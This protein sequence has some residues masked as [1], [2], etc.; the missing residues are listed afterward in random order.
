MIDIQGGFSII[1]KVA[2]THIFTCHFFLPNQTD[3][4]I[5]IFLLWTNMMI[6]RFAPQATLQLLGI[7]L[8]YNMAGFKGI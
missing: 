4:L 8:I 7:E 3:T 6:C 5:L 2:D 1:A